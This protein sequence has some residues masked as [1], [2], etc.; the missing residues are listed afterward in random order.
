MDM[1]TGRVY[2][3]EEGKQAVAERKVSPHDLQPVRSAAA[4]VANPNECE[5]CRRTIRIRAS[6]PGKQGSDGVMRHWCKRCF[7]KI[8]GYR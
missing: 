6:T 1:R 5:R 8:G 2:S 3:H 4:V 7:K